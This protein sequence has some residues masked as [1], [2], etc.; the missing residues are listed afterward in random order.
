MKKLNDIHYAACIEYTS[1][2]QS[3]I[4]SFKESADKLMK[5]YK[6]RGGKKELRYIK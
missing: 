2:L 6:N 4:K 1:Y 5:E 3:H